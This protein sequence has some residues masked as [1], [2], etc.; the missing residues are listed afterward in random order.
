M[1]RPGWQ[2]SENT[3]CEETLRGWFALFQLKPKRV[4]ASPLWFSAS[5]LYPGSVLTIAGRVGRGQVC[6]IKGLEAG[7]PISSLFCLRACVLGLA[8]LV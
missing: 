2:V 3:P 5:R 6:S 1:G 8:I 7:R 4:R